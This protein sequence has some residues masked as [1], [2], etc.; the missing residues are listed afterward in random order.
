[1]T[2]GLIATLSRGLVTRR[3]MVEVS[4][5]A[6]GTE[7]SEEESAITVTEITEPVTGLSDYGWR[8]IRG[9][10]NP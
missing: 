10:T 3:T 2:T 5:G 9:E 4:G 1:M 6:Q 7:I 8:R